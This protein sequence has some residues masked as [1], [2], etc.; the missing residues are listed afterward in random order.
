MNDARIATT[1]SE[2]QLNMQGKSYMV[3]TEDDEKMT[4]KKWHDFFI[5]Y[6]QMTAV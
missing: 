3:P 1:I 5:T 6:E 2:K 4:W